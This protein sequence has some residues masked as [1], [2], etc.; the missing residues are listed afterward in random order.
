MSNSLPTYQYRPEEDEP[1][2]TA[3]VTALS[4]A[5][6]R[7]ITEDECVLYDS[8]DPEALDGLFRG[9][10]GDDTIKVE[11]S[12]HDA[13]VIIWGNGSL[14]IQVEDLEADPNHE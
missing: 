3:I 2:S 12:T 13:I 5:K 7:D 1:L 9:E 10:S 14:T 6:G 4:E 11:F 8:I